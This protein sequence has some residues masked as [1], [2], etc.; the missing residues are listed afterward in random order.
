MIRKNKAD[1]IFGLCRWPSLLLGLLV[2]TGCSS[3]PE[4]SISVKG[5]VTEIAQSQ[6]LNIDWPNLSKTYKLADHHG[7]GTSDAKIAQPIFNNEVVLIGLTKVKGKWKAHIGEEKN[8]EELAINLATG[9]I[10]LLA[11]ARPYKPILGGNEPPKVQ[12]IF[13]PD[14]NAMCAKGLLTIFGNEQG[15]D[16]CNSN[17][18]Y[19]SADYNVVEIFSD[20]VTSL[21]Q[22][23]VLTKFYKVKFDGESIKD[24]LNE[25]KIYE[26]L[27]NVAADKRYKDFEYD[28][29]DSMVNKIKLGAF[30]EKYGQISQLRNHAY[31]VT[32]RQQA[33]EFELTTA[34]KIDK[35]R[36]VINKYE[37]DDGD[38]LLHQAKMRLQK[39][40]NDENIKS[41]FAKAEAQKAAENKRMELQRKNLKEKRELENW[42]KN[43]SLGDD[44]FCGRI[45]DVNSNSTMFK[46]AISAKLPGYGNEQWVHINELYQPWRGCMNRNGILTPNYN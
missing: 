6:H 3:T 30:V 36:F 29:N 7:Y 4:Q 25:T 19:I 43:L 40:E 35:L 41:E 22:A 45:V 12:H 34:N 42:R 44:T 21:G 27:I 1:Y 13:S 24:V 23:V 2:L 5:Y 26:H 31:I 11:H 32:A 17:F 46:L 38:K 9:D 16:L 14:I 28:Y 10:T 37:G 8:G 33:R 18:S 15:R 20:A 39:L